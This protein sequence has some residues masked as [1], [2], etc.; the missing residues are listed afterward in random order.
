M[1]LISL[2]LSTS[3]ASA[4]TYLIPTIHSL[5]KS[6]RNYSYDSLRTVIKRLNP[7]VIAVEIR[8][9]DLTSDSLYLASNYPLE[10]RAMKNW[11]PK[12][13]IAGIDWLGPEL[14]GR[15]IPPNYWREQSEIKKL[16][17]AKSQD[18][19]YAQNALKCTGI[20]QKRVAGL[21]SATLRQIV[22][23]QDTPLTKAFYKCQ[24]EVFAGSA[25]M[26]VLDFYRER[27][28]KILEN[29]NKVIAENKGKRI[30]ILLGADHFAMLR[31]KFP[32]TVKYN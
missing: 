18:P 26:K 32:N 31:D 4:Q 7:E 8:A 25:H 30:V 24:D 2:V 14:E 28:R 10:M 20:Q 22:T 15:P 12:A 21:R 1:A 3:A 5:H 19:L 27:D 16:E 23:G 6:N 9:I 11:F 13:A 17:V 29:I